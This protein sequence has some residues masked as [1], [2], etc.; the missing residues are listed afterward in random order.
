[1]LEELEVEVTLPVVVAQLVLVV[2]ADK[3]KVRVHLDQ[4][5][6][7]IKAVEVAEVLVLHLLVDQA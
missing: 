1:M 7:Q 2:Q 4:L 3:G 6:R 5:E